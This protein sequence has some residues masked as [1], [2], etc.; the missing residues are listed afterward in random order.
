MTVAELVVV[1]GILIAAFLAAVAVILAR[2]VAIRV[3][4]ARSSLR[5]DAAW[6]AQ[7]EQDRNALAAVITE[8][9]ARPATYSTFPPDL[10]DAIYAAHSGAAELERKAH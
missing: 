6:R 9:D 8:L 1:P 2:A 5:L 3:R 10:R 4:A 7:Y